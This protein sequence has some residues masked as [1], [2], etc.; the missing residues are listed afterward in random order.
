MLLKHDLLML[1]HA[2]FIYCHMASHG[3]GELLQFTWSMVESVE[4]AGVK[5]LPLFSNAL[6][7]TFGPA[8]NHFFGR[9]EAPVSLALSGASK[10]WLWIGP[11]DM[12]SVQKRSALQHI[13]ASNGMKRKLG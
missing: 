7:A 6:L 5:F 4:I 13:S 10:A 12:L 3:H 1:K 8:T 9:Q 11:Q 2:Y